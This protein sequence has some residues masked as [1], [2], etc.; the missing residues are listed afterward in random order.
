[1]GFGLVW[2]AGGRTCFSAG[3]AVMK[4]YALR[5]SLQRVFLTN[6]CAGL[7]REFF[8]LTPDTVRADE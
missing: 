5:I 2:R 1:S 3:G 8:R 7:R 4:K 6:L